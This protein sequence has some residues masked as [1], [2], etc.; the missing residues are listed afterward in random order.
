VRSRF[1]EI[2]T[3]ARPGGDE[4]MEVPISFDYEGTKIL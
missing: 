1:A 2:S 4:H 3:G